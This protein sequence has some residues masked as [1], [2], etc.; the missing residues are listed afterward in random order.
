MRDGKQNILTSWHLHFICSLF[1]VAVFAG[2]AFERNSIWQD[3][4]SL[5]EDAA[6]KSPRIGRIYNN[7]GE[8]YHRKRQLAKALENYSMAIRLS[9]ASSLD[10]YSNIG[11]IYV[12]LGEHE[13]AVRIFSQLL[14]I[15]QNDAI[16]YASRGHAYY[17]QG[18]YDNAIR[19]FDTSLQLS[20]RNPTVHFYRGSCYEKKGNRL[21]A[22]Q[23]FK[24]ACALGESNA[25][26]KLSSH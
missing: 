21:A 24:T 26:V 1:I 7:L 10:A 17:R 13:K 18:L 14:L 15:D 22:F 2:S 12:D 19:D 23:D 6:R 5:W 9:P 20:Q 8:A 3:P 4:V 25:C 11:S 16:A